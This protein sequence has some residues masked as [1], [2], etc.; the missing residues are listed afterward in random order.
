[1]RLELSQAPAPASA[2]TATALQNSL[3]RPANEEGAPTGR[4]NS[5][6][7]KQSP[8]TV[9]CKRRR[10]PSREA[11]RTHVYACP[12]ALRAFS[13]LPRRPRQVEGVGA[14]GTGGSLE[15]GAAEGVPRWG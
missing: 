7:R 3:S 11:I 14:A 9:T 10:L 8:G 4:T 6:S 5:R 13:M 2:N 15:E 12:P 1:V